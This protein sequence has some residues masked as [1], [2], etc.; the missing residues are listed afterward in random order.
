MV[1]AYLSEAFQ[2]QLDL[3]TKYSAGKI[4]FIYFSTT[5]YNYRQVWFEVLVQL[6]RSNYVS[7]MVTVSL[8]T[9]TALARCGDLGIINERIYG[10][11][12]LIYKLYKR[13]PNCRKMSTPDARTNVIVS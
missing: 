2:H 5:G 9:R 11:S 3:S 7:L 1:N 12:F 10:F 8:M 13:V 4:P 6:N